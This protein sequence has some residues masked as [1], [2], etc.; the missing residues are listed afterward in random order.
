MELNIVLDM[1]NEIH[2]SQSKRMLN[3]IPAF[4]LSLTDQYEEHMEVQV[5]EVAGANR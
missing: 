1:K 2:S 4:H 5:L 3:D